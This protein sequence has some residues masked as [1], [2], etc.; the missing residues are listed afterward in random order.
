MKNSTPVY[1]ITGN[2]NDKCYLCK[3]HLSNI[4]L[5]G[6][7]ASQAV[8]TRYLL[9]MLFW[10]CFLMVLSSVSSSD[11]YGSMLKLFKACFTVIYGFL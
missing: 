3:L 5:S 2:F 6:S 10:A 11:N 9:A 8:V 7:S 4:Y 1:S